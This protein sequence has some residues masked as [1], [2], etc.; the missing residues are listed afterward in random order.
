MARKVLG[1]SHGIAV[2][3]FYDKK[4]TFSAISTIRPDTKAIIVQVRMLYERDEYDSLL[5]KFKQV[6]ASAEFD[7]KKS[8]Q[9]FTAELI[10][11]LLYQRYGL[12]LET[13]GEEEE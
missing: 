1:N 11:V 4:Y 13:A 6:S 3:E 8:M 7:S 2:G 9:E 12:P 10:S 5:S